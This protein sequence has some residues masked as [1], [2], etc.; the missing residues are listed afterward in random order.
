MRRR[1]QQ[2]HL[3][4]PTDWFGAE[5]Q[6]LCNTGPVQAQHVQ[7]MPQ[8]LLIKAE[9][10]SQD[11][12]K[13]HRNMALINFTDSSQISGPFNFLHTIQKLRSL[14]STQYIWKDQHSATYS[15]YICFEQCSLAVDFHCRMM[16]PMF[17]NMRFTWVFTV[18]KL[19][20]RE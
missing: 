15:T 3:I 2:H 8:V 17:V 20:H 4:R 9:G 7:P 10:H 14:F 19:L 12:Y 1:L 13:M 6:D 18:I 16:Q 11:C 5:L